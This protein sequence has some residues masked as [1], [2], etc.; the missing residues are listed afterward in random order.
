MRIAQLANFVGPRSGG[1]GTALRALGAG[2]VGA[3]AQRLL[4]VP[5]PKDVVTSTAAGDVVQIRSPRVS[6]GYRLIVEP[7]RVVNALR[8]FGPT[9]VEL[10]DKLTLVPIADWAGRHGVRSVLFSH[11]RLDDMWAGYSGL[12]GAARGTV[13]VLN[14]TL[15]RRFD[16]IVVTS[17]Y[18]QSEF[19]ALADAVGCPVQRVPL[20]VDLHTFRPY[21]A[22]AGTHS[23]SS[24]TLRLIYVGRLSREKS[25]DLAVATAVE[26]HRRGVDVRLDVYGDGGQRARLEQQ[27]AGDPVVFHGFV[28]DRADLGRRIAAAD[29]SLSVCPDETFGLA[30]LEAL[31][32]GTPVVTAAR[33]GARELIDAGSG[34]WGEPD[35]GCLADAVLEVVTRPVDARRAA[36]RRRAELFPW[37]ATVQRMLQVH[38]GAESGHGALVG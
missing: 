13:R 25:P 3:G 16:T 12:G 17:R 32:S 23:R 30:V 4:V 38:A 34:A 6:G 27:A 24:P 20:G 33:G 26:L 31:A 21:G 14:R 8:R 28:T 18:A 29:V 1:M 11:E 2:Y 15:V 7:W 35:P 36:A 5:G 9:S 22:A 10:S 37:S 19:Q